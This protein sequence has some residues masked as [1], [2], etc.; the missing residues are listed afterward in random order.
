MDT[1]PS[2][3]YGTTGMMKPITERLVMARINRA[4]KDG[5]QLHKCR[6]TSKLF[7]LCGTYWL[8]DSDGNIVKDHIDLEK[9]G[10]EMGVIAEWE[11]MVG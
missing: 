8:Q 2:Q 4:L 6:K 7:G 10:R 3:P 11:I 9:M 5:Q 1:H